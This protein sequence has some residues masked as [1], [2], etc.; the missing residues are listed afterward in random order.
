MDN[1]SLHG[2]GLTAQNLKENR[3]IAGPYLEFSPDFAPSDFFLFGAL[4]VFDSSEI[5]LWS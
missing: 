3:L 4:D 1:A 2:V 5:R